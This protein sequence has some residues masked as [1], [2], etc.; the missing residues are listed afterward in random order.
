MKVIQIN[1]L[2]A[3]LSTGRTTREMHNYFKE[4]GIESRIVC[5]A[6]LDC[7]DAFFFSDRKSMR[8]DT[9]LTMLTGLEGYH[10]KKQT[11]R[12][13]EYL[14]NEK[15]DVVHLRILHSN[16]INLRMLLQ[17]LAKKDIA[18]VIT[19]HDFWFLTGKCCFFTT[20]N[21]D[22][23]MTGCYKCPAPQVKNR[24]RLFEQSKK[25]WLDKKKWLQSIDRLAFI[26]VSDWVVE[27]AKKAEICKDKIVRR[28]YNW[29]DLNVFY[30]R[31]EEKETARE[32]YN[33]QDKFVILGVSAVWEKS[34]RKGLDNYIELSKRL[35]ADM[36]IVLVGNMNCDDPL[37]EN[38]ISVGSVSDKEQ[39][40]VLYSLADVYLNLST[41]ETFGKV[42]AESLA[43]GTPVIAID[44]TV[45]KEL[46]LDSCG[47]V[48]PNCDVDTM[49]SAVEKIHGNTKAYY[50]DACRAFAEN[51][52]CMEDNIKQYCEL[53]RS[54]LDD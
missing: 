4:H 2:G 22:R 42:T 25:M 54:L 39:L 26:G 18:T 38:I 52:F 31:K 13:L 7:D 34:D 6:P 36:V 53:Y 48:I 9:L 37:P 50:E 15:P 21:C 30:P 35:P 32:K 29:I 1:A 33:L 40:A 16:C 5:P 47:V 19:M 12:L 49:L 11:K 44:A 45:N 24:P 46:V 8:F 17:Y 3:T 10:S 20:N 41:A 14:N 43:C 51:N 28:I 23:W 27:Q